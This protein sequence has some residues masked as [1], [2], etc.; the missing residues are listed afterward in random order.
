MNDDII[1]LSLVMYVIEG[2]IKFSNVWAQFIMTSISVY[3]MCTSSIIM[4]PY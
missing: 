3:L 4:F 2:L 1:K